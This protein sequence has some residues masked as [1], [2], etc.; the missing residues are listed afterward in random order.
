MLT[1]RATDSSFSEKNYC[2][3]EAKPEPHYSNCKPCRCT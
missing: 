2:D 3:P 1:Q